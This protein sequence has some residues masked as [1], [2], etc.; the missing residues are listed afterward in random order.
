MLVQQLTNAMV[1][2]FHSSV[3]S[4]LV[5]SI[6]QVRNSDS[7]GSI[8]QIFTNGVGLV[9]VLS[10][11]LMVIALAFV[12]FPGAI[13]N[14]EPDQLFN[15][16]LAIA[17][18]AV[19]ISLIVITSPWLSLF[20]ICQRPIMY[21]VDLTIRRWLDLIA[22][23]LAM[24]P[25]G[26]DLFAAF[27]LIRMVL[28]IFHA[29]AR[30]LIAR[31]VMKEAR[32]DWS[33]LDRSIMSRLTRLGGVT[34]VEPFTN[35]NFFV[36]DNYLLN[37]V[38]GTIYN[39]IYAIVNQLRGY[40]R[41]F[42]S[43]V[44]VG[45]V[46]IAAD[47]HERGQRQTNIRAMLA[48]SRITSGVMLLSTGIIVI[49]FRPMIDL[50]LGSRLKQD[51]SLLEIMSYQ[52]AVD[53]VWGMLSML[54]IGGILL[55]SVAAASKFLYG[56]GLVK[57][58]A[59]V[60]L[61]AGV[62]KFILSVAAA[63]IMLY[64]VTDIAEY[65]NASLAFSG[66]TLFCQLIFFGILMPR[67]IVK[68]AEINMSTWWWHVLA[69]PVMAAIVPMMAGVA[70]IVFVGTW[71][72]VWLIVSILIV[73]ILC[74][75]SSFFLLLEREERQRF[76]NLSSRLPVISRFMGTGRDLQGEGEGP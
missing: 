19:I 29:L 9:L 36:L 44:F 52:E 20:L 25:F 67:R 43:Q 27:V 21:N 38:F 13:L 39:G 47:I 10:V 49:F 41:R 53:L 23:G 4:T 68:L 73:G 40:A 46:A 42:G 64:A 2:P 70:L 48:V 65:P 15:L 31:R 34:A 16:R 11:C 3:T 76:L 22:F 63:M 17:T 62:L 69:R 32:L 28:K 18:E 57:K 59:G 26:W 51:E 50:W 8:S 75:P 14:F 61:G 45:T 58:Y 66:I 7:T 24:L 37:I 72:W 1:G 5:K 71:T 60:L 33:L 74:I 54:L 55:E 30:I 12:I 56:M 6:S 35:F